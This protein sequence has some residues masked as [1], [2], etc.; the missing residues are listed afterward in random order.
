MSKQ[1]NQASAEPAPSGSSVLQLP[2][3]LLVLD[4]TFHKYFHP[5]AENRINLNPDFALNMVQ[6]WYD[7]NEPAHL[8]PKEAGKNLEI[9]IRE[10]ATDF[11]AFLTGSHAHEQSRRGSVGQKEYPPHYF[12]TVEKHW[13]LD[14]SNDFFLYDDRSHIGFLKLSCRHTGVTLSRRRDKENPGNPDTGNTILTA[15][16]RLFVENHIQLEDKSAIP[17]G[18]PG[19][20]PV[21]Q[22]VKMPGTDLFKLDLRTAALIFDTYIKGR[23]ASQKIIEPNTPILIS[24]KVD[25]PKYL[26]QSTCSAFDHIEGEIY[27]LGDN[28]KLPP[29]D[30]EE[31]KRTRIFLSADRGYFRLNSEDHRNAAKCRAMIRMFQEK[32]FVYPDY[33]STENQS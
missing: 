6:Y 16:L 32:F 8:Y 14:D 12:S 7:W 5:D 3:D 30:S 25:R 19:E 17:P 9:A 23:F 10:M 33:K 27:V 29:D 24:D 15:M 2:P 4:D 13:K 22:S 28:P 20:P 21:S 31:R 18:Q 1:T 11:A 26:A